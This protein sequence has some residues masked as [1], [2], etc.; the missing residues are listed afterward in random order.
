LRFN[1]LVGA[2]VKFDKSG[3]AALGWSVVSFGLQVAAN[4]GK[5]REFVCK[6]SEVVTG[7]MTRYLEYEIHFRGP[8]ADEGF[9]LRMKNV[10]KAILLY[11]IALHDYLR[12]C[13]AGWFSELW[14][15]CI[16]S[17]NYFRSP[18]TRSL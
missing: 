16:D 3:Y 1:S 10:Y 15:L 18:Y 14:M 13:E 5:A 9:D 8:E 6:S 7:Y 17:S 4:A 2:A 12:R 11:V